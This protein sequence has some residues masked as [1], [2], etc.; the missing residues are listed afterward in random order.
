[1]CGWTTTAGELDVMWKGCAAD[2]HHLER[3]A[4]D[5]RQNVGADGIMLTRSEERSGR[6]L[7]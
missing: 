3:G 6:D 2:R 5:S 4:S 1:M 7:M